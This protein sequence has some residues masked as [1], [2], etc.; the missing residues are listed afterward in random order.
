M[1]IRMMSGLE[2]LDLAQGGS[3]PNADVGQVRHEL[4]FPRGR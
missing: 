2:G 3:W 4:T 1:R